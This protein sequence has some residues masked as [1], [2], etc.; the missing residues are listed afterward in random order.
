MSSDEGW[1]VWLDHSE[2]RLEKVSEYLDHDDDGSGV[3][4]DDDEQ[5]LNLLHKKRMISCE[6]FTWKQSICPECQH[7]FSCEQVVFLDDDPDDP[8]CE[9]QEHILKF[10]TKDCECLDSEFAHCPR[11]SH[12]FTCLEADCEN[13]EHETELKKQRFN[14]IEYC[15]CFGALNACVTCGHIGKCDTGDLCPDSRLFHENFKGQETESSKVPVF[16]MKRWTREQDELLIEL[17]KTQTGFDEIANQLGRTQN[18]IIARLVKLSFNCPS[19]QIKRFL[20]RLNSG[21]LKWPNHEI[22]ALAILFAANQELDVIEK[23]LNRDSVSLAFQ[24]VILRLASPA[25]L[26]EY[27]LPKKIQQ[28]TAAELTQ[29]R[30]DF[31]NKVPIAFMAE[32]AGRTKYSVLNVLYSLGEITDSDVDAMLQD[33]STTAYGD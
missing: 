17:Y 9:D 31:R 22:D 13:L 21:Y 33:A 15:Y 6:C 27:G 2:K 5:D 10:Q 7:D 20:A 28:W 3:Y 16:A 8:D 25:T 30:V 26:P 12:I 18:S 19:E 32:N 24:L 14:N 11:C 1:E 4:E 29:L 23:Q